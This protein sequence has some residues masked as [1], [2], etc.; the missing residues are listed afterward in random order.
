[1]NSRQQVDDRDIP[2]PRLRLNQWISTTP[3]AT[4]CII[5]FMALFS[6][7]NLVFSNL[8]NVI[9]LFAVLH[10]ELW[11]L[12]TATFVANGLLSLIFMSVSIN[13]FATKLERAIGSLP[14]FL[15][16]VFIAIGISTCFVLCCVTLA[17]NPIKTYKPAM[18]WSGS[19]IWGTI[20]AWSVVESKIYPQIERSLFMLPWKIP[21]KHYPVALLILLS[22][23]GFSLFLPI[24]Y[25]LGHLI[26]RETISRATLQ[27][28][29]NSNDESI[30]S[31]L[32]ISRSGY[33]SLSSAAGG[34]ALV[35]G[36]NSGS[37]ATEVEMGVGSSIGVTGGGH[38][39]GTT[40][41]GQV[42]SAVDELF[43]DPS[44]AAALAAER[45]L[46][47]QQRSVE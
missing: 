17:F 29:E 40:M 28:Y 38:T 25:V 21:S 12:F 43:V 47:R 34:E 14:F 2:D 5:I 10:L 11:R 15:M 19:G 16:T 23:F 3:P 7:V 30:L 27:S 18:V 33:V 32:L 37:N 8:L 31:F 6:I 41:E 42:P 46:Q 20:V 13:Y 9:P 39:L 45:R 44:E 24:G 26:N 36:D 4:L 35:V 22:F 1:M